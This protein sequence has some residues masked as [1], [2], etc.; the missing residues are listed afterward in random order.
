M[1]EISALKKQQLALSN[2]N[3]SW[4]QYQL[5]IM[6]VESKLKSLTK[7]QSQVSIATRKTGKATGGL[8]SKFGGLG[9]VLK[10]AGVI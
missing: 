6:K 8:S 10:G 9:K 4:L 5:R 2:S 7:V 1:N 3:K